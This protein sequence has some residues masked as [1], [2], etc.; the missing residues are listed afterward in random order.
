L[1]SE[2]ALEAAHAHTQDWPPPTAPPHALFAGDGEFLAL[3]QPNAD[4]TAKYLAVF[5]QP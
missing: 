4:G 5:S 3:A 1:S 2:Q